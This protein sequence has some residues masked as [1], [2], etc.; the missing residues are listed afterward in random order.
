MSTREERL[1][2]VARRASRFFRTPGYLR[3]PHEDLLLARELASV[4][5]GCDDIE[6]THDADRAEWKQRQEFAASMVNVR[7]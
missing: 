4:L 5:D 1:V 6:P 2:D 7:R 3:G